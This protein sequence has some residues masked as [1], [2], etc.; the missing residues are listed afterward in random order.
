MNKLEEMFNS[1]EASEA[2]KEWDKKNEATK[3]LLSKKEVLCAMGDLAS[4]I[5]DITSGE[6]PHQTIT[7]LAAIKVDSIVNEL[8][9]DGGEEQVYERI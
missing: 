4:E 8:F 1:V 9:R 3:K 5:I 6:N 2:F 7:F